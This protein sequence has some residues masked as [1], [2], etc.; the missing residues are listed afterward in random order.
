MTLR[1]ALRNL[2][3]NRR[4]TVLNLAL[5]SGG[6][7]AVVI[8]K[9]FAANI[10]ESTKWGAV[11]SQYGHIQIAKSSLW[12]KNADDSLRDKLLQDPNTLV[13]KIRGWQGIRSVAPRL[14]FYGLISNGDRSVAAQIVGI[15]P[16]IETQILTDR[17]R[18]AGHPFPNPITAESIYLAAVGEGVAT[19]IGLKP[20]DNITVIGQ[21]IDGAINAMDASVQMVFRTVIQEIDDTTI[22][23]PLAFAQKLLDS[24]SAERVLIVLEHHDL[25]DRTIA[26][27]V[28][29]AA[30]VITADQ[31][32]RSWRDLARLYN[33]TEDFFTVQNA[34][35][36]TIIFSLIFLSTV[37]A[38]S[39]SVSERIGEVGTMRAIGR[40]RKQALTLFTVEG[41]LLGLIGATVGGALSIV[42]GTLLNRAKL[43]MVIPG[44]TQTIPIHIEFIPS[45]FAYAFLA[46]VS[47]SVFASFF[48]A[49]RAVKMKIVD[50]L[51]HNI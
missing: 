15:E 29:P 50:C 13:A 43:P 21:T 19:A 35:V 36:A 20:G 9:G 49:R 33:Q 7:I 17:A 16:N 2:F 1:L 40:T 30:P 37:G 8:F 42:V 47:A 24:E 51:K 48:T 10:L 23:V 12:K 32:V 31:G 45:A 38:V 6:F 11:N 27:I 26:K 5:I 14:S 25:V 34:V 39:M 46:I 41:L 18:V 3:R 4:R 28:D 44:A 22:Y